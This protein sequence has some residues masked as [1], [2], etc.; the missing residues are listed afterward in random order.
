MG[1]TL[2]P[3]EMNA[4]YITVR[5]PA[6]HASAFC[7]ETNEPAFGNLVIHSLEYLAARPGSP[8]FKKEKLNCFE[9][10]WIKSGEA[11][12]TVDLRDH[13]IGS[14][15]MVCLGPEQTRQIH[16]PG[17]TQ[18][19]YIR[20]APQL[21]NPI[22]ASPFPSLQTIGWNNPLVLH[23]GGIMG[24]AEEVLLTLA[25]ELWTHENQLEEIISHYF[26]IFMIYLQKGCT[27]T[28]GNM[29]FTREA[30][31]M[32]EFIR[33][34]KQ[35]FIDQKN[36]SDY[37]SKLGVTPGYLSRVV[38]KV[39][40]LPASYHIRHCIIV[41]AKKMAQ[42]PQTSMKEIAYALGFEDNAH[43][44]KFFKCYASMNFTSYR[45]VTY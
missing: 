32:R 22:E 30:G 43:F 27:V 34:L 37:A 3:R 26:R 23:T 14:Q 16:L 1:G 45:R 25:R 29:A 44:S 33:L 10:L 18:G 15:S 41:E 2:I 7:Q 6:T 4:T 42:K 38:K 21:L 35:H 24:Q 11:L 40:G 28:E 20:F 17:D 31:L 36:V 19:Y 13:V 12:V 8:P 5:Q 39:S 9:M